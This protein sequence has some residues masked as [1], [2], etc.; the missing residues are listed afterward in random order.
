VADSFDLHALD[1]ALRK[2]VVESNLPLGLAPKLSTLIE[3]ASLEKVD[4]KK[5][6]VARKSSIK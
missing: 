6:M 5:L 3:E 4:E 2:D 1:H